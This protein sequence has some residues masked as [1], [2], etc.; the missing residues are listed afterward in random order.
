MDPVTVWVVAPPDDTGLSS[1]ARPPAGVRFVVG[2]KAEDFATAPPADVLLA[3][4]VG[5]RVFEPVFAMAPN[6]RWVHSRSAGLDGLLFPALVEGPV[7]LT[8]AKGVY[9]ES[10]A[11][12][13][14]AG[15]L[16]FAKDFPRMRRNQAAGR[17]EQF[18][19]EE[20]AGRTLLVLGYGDIGR[21]AGRKAR[22]LGMKVIGLRR[23]AE[24][25][26]GDD[27]A[28][29]IGALGDRL[30]FLP[31][32]DYVAVAAPLVPESRKLVGEAE[33][34]A[35]KPSAV[36]INVGRGPVIDEEALVRALEQGRIRG[37][38]LDV[39]EEEPLPV[40]HPFYRLENVLLSPHCADHT[41]T[42]LEDSMQLFLRNLERFRK[43]EPLLNR[44]A[45]K[46]RGY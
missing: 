11:E 42:W 5:R 1:L 21:A 41:A 6:V 26:P 24:R 38:A 8:N 31:R 17:W 29:E 30:D 23:T 34:A 3:C 44:V 14:I 22:A 33:I 16:F 25:P 2:S 27:V 13:V 9:S 20:I 19:V 43:G 12:F 10:L 37:A 18:D 28:D 32:A 7:V 46:A 40:G 36:V 15:A 4:A 45:D 35:M 39:F